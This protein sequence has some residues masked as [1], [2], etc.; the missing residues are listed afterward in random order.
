LIHLYSDPDVEEVLLSP[1]EGMTPLT[2]KRLKSMQKAVI[3]VAIPDGPEA[4]ALA[5]A[6][7]TMAHM[8][9]LG[10]GS[11]PKTEPYPGKQDNEGDQAYRPSRPHRW[12]RKG[13]DRPQRDGEGNLVLIWVDDSESYGETCRSPGL[14]TIDL[15]PYFNA[16]QTLGSM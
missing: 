8:R 16:A 12:P 15:R 3:A 1:K 4:L 7:Q 13:D 10:H 9:V 5:V 6:I 14:H 2:D 11:W